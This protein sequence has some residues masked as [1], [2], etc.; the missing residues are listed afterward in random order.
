MFKH[1]ESAGTRSEIANNNGR[2]VVSQAEIFYDKFILYHLA[3]QFQSV[4]LL[5]ADEC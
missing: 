2:A 3:C 4:T 1:S 5:S